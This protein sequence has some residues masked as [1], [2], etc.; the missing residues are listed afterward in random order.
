MIRIGEISYLNCT[1][2]FTLLRENYPDSDYLF[3]AGTPAELNARLRSGDIALCPSSSIEYARNPELYF[4][5]PELSISSF[6]PVKSVFLFSRLPIERLDGAAIGLTI[7]SETSVA[8]LKI[9]LSRKYSFNNTFKQSSGNLD[10]VL[11]E[12][13]AMLLIGDAALRSAV[14][15]RDGYLYDLGELW[16]E[17]TGLPFVFALW[18]IREDA[19]NQAADEYYLLRD[20]LIAAKL[21]AVRD[22][23]RI[24]GL[25]KGNNWTNRELLINYWKTISYDLSP[26]HVEGLRL[27]FRYAA[28]CGIV[29]NEPLL[30]FLN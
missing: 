14:S 12:N 11:A 25:L 2:I 22:F 20:R 3:I 30:R 24:A 10:E 18:L 13:E 21:A 9:L 27:Y 4:I 7:E 23:E 16:R 26:S 29:G 1:P 28:E 8:L 6:G 15:Y 5:L 19:F 17:F